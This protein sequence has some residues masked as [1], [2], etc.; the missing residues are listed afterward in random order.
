MRVLAFVFLLLTPIAAAADDAVDKAIRDLASE[1]AAVRDAAEKALRDK[2]E[3]A[4]EA[5]R[6]AM[7]VSKDAEAK[8]R[9]SK[10]VESLEAAGRLARL[11]EIWTDQWF[12]TEETSREDE[13]D[14]PLPGQPKEKKKLRKGWAHFKASPTT[15][16]GR[17]AWKLLV[18]REKP[19]GEKQTS[20]D[21]WEGTVLD[22]DALSPLQLVWSFGTRKGANDEGVASCRMTFS[23]NRCKMEVLKS[24]E[25]LKE[26]D[27]VREEP[28]RRQTEDP[29]AILELLPQVVERAAISHAGSV[30]VC[31]FPYGEGEW[32]AFEI[33]FKEETSIQIGNEDVAARLYTCQDPESEEPWEFWVSDTRGLMKMRTH[34]SVMTRA[35]EA[36]ARPPGVAPQ[37]PPDMAALRPVHDALREALR[38]EDW[39]AVRAQIGAKFDE[40]SKYPLS[41]RDHFLKQGGEPLKRFAARLGTDI[42]GLKRLGTEALT[43]R[44]HFGVLPSGKDD[45]VV[46]WTGLSRE[47]QGSIEFVTAESSLHAWYYEWKDGKWSFEILGGFSSGEY[48]K[49]ATPVAALEQW[50]RAVLRG[51]GRDLWGC[52]TARARCRWILA[53]WKELDEARAAGDAAMAKLAARYKVGPKELKK[54]NVNAFAE[55]VAEFTASTLSATEKKLFEA[56]RWEPANVSDASAKCRCVE[57]AGSGKDWVLQNEGEESWRIDTDPLFDLF[58]ARRK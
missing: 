34:S 28:I 57:G 2:G 54:K 19:L 47:G 13:F 21:T 16:K 44:G 15:D 56:L 36:T 5:C 58:K 50:K 45:A 14:P 40:L 8:A 10:I 7:G 6:K 24:E 1:D 11:P 42:E 26:K 46:V 31:L 3:P 17:K 23:T 12:V 20:V 33:R 29:L 27:R 37:A 52:L 4:L 53:S 49:P 55:M 38:K 25:D 18:E 32:M 30:R 9:L 35:D 22:D 51:S 41:W 43:A 48:G 39:K